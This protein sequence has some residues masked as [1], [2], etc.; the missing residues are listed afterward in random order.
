MADNQSNNVLTKNNMRS[1]IEF[2]VSSKLQL[3][4]SLNNICVRAR[5]RA[6]NT[7]EMCGFEEQINKHPIYSNR[8]GVKNKL[9][10]GSIT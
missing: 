5:A 10:T 3:F 1:G 9:L 4:R 7:V 8:V 2:L 6:C